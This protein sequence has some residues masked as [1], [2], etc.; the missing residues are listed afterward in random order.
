MDYYKRNNC[1]LCNGKNLE[2]VINLSSTPIGDDFIP[3]ECLDKQ[4]KVY[5]LDL[6]FCKDCS[7]IQILGIIN[8]EKIYRDYIYESKISLGLSKHFKQ[9]AEHICNKLSIENN[10]L[11]IDIGSNDGSLLNGF[12][13]LDMNVLGVEPAINIANNATRLGIETIAEFF[14]SELATAIK[15]KRATATIITA[16]NVFANIDNLDDIIEGLKQLMR[17]D[18]CFIL[19]TGYG[20]DTVQNLV[21]DNIYH[22]HLS[23]FSVKPLRLYFEKHGMELIDVERIPTKGGSIRCFVQ[24][25]NGKRKRNPI[26]NELINLETELG[27]DSS[28]PLKVFKDRVEETKRNLIALITSLKNQGKSIA[29]YGASVGVTTLLYYFGLG[30]TLEN[31]YDDNSIKHNLFSPG[32]HIP[33]HKSNAIYDK[34]PDY[35]IIFPWRYAGNIIKKHKKY[36]KNGGHFIK[37]LPSVEIIGV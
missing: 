21:F 13:N 3:Y 10:S 36:L 8:K 9:Y 30:N 15:D 5:P 7:L 24:L 23:Y 11:I 6:F 27:F 22:E 2:H 28:V 29:G 32:H 20:I 4:Q 12:K 14:T 26:V 18:S 19:E 16:N 25:K 35:I 34:N 33:I 31:L 1:R 37:V 17:K